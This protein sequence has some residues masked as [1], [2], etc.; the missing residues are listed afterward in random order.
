MQEDKHG[1]GFTRRPIVYQMRQ[2]ARATRLDIYINW[3][4][5]EL[6]TLVSA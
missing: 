1:T 6:I 5:E 3:F 4:H 2:A